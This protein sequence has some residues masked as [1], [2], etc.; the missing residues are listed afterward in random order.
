MSRRCAGEEERTQREPEE[1]G[2]GVGSAYG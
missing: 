2:R 1:N